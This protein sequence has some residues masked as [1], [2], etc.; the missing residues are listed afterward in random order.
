MEV[1]DFFPAYTYKN[2]SIFWN[3]SQ[4]LPDS[5]TWDLAQKLVTKHSN[6]RKHITYGVFFIDIIFNSLKEKVF[7]IQSELKDSTTDWTL[8]RMWKSKRKIKSSQ[9]ISVT[10]TLQVWRCSCVE[11]WL[12]SINH[13]NGCSDGWCVYMRCTFPRQGAISGF[14]VKWWGLQNFLSLNSQKIFIIR[15]LKVIKR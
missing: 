10:F 9:L 13:R 2:G 15:G 3:I 1:V 7:P 5:W 8:D 11:L 14:L 12:S 4:E 6:T